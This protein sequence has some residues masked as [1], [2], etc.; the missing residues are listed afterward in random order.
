M[1]PT[2]DNIAIL[3]VE[4]LLIE[5]LDSMLSPTYVMSLTPTLISKIASESSDNSVQRERLSG[6]TT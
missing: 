1:K 4:K 5:G 2:I 6:Y 3:A